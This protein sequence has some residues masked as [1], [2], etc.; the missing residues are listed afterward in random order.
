LLAS[1]LVVQV[2]APALSMQALPDAHDG[3]HLASS[4]C[5]VQTLVSAMHAVPEAQSAVRQGVLLE[6]SAPLSPPAAIVP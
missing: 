6:T 4:S 5:A 3:V 2:G 1:I